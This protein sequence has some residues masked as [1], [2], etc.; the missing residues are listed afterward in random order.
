[1]E[2]TKPLTK[3]TR[4]KVTVTGNESNGEHMQENRNSRIA[5]AAYYKAQERG[6]Q[7]G[8][9]LDDWLTAEVEVNNEY[10]Q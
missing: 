9:E 7:P 6:F 2:P 8:H 5:I 10:Y 4:K 3:N 1:M